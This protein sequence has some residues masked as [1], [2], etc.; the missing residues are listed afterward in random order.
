MTQRDDFSPQSPVSLDEA[1]SV[2]LRGLVKVGTLRRAADRG[3]LATERLGRAIV[4]TPADIEAW[5]KL[6][7]DRQ[8][9][10]AYGSD[11]REPK[12][13]NAAPPSGSSSTESIRKAQA[14][15]LATAQKLKDGL[16]T[17][18]PKNTPQKGSTVVPLPQ[19]RSQTS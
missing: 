13:T 1:A 8:K 11:R 16:R 5:R 7:R 15:A 10:L 17:T 19:S 3:E 12:E 6:C 9:A 4:T 18:S 2:L 14:A